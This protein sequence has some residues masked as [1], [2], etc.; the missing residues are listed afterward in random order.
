MPTLLT[1][2]DDVD[3]VIKLNSTTYEPEGVTAD[4]PYAYETPNEPPSATD[5]ARDLRMLGSRDGSMVYTPRMK[6]ISTDATYVNN[7][8]TT[9][10]LVSFGT[11]FGDADGTRAS[12]E[13]SS[14]MCQHPLFPL[15]VANALVDDS[16][17]KVMPHLVFL[18]VYSAASSSNIYPVFRPYLWPRTDSSAKGADG[19]AKFIPDAT[20]ST[21]YFADDS[22]A[23]D[24]ILV[25][26]DLMNCNMWAAADEDGDKNTADKS[27]D[28]TYLH[29]TSHTATVKMLLVYGDTTDIAG[30]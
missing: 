21:G 27:D 8:N 9:L 23:N 19:D 7:A 29:L 11:R 26:L 1:T 16:G 10:N 5:A 24:D 18:Q 2:T 15:I 22:T 28:S 13:L 6:L 14:T 25:G 20:S 17:D 3:K 30:F 12:T 4:P